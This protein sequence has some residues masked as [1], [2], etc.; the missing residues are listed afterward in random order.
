MGG[1]GEALQVVDER[2]AVAGGARAGEV[3]AGVPVE[4]REID[5]LAGDRTPMPRAP[6]TRA[7][8][9]RLVPVV[10]APLGEGGLGD[11][12]I[13][14]ASG[15]AV[16][17]ASL[18]RRA[19]RRPRAFAAAGVD[20]TVVEEREGA[21]RVLSLQPKRRWRGAIRMVASSRARAKPSVGLSPEEQLD[22]DALVDVERHDLG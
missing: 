7:S 18:S 4:G 15:T 3:G 10:L 12:E 16:A 17:R 14:S 11:G 9:S 20:R 1:R 13:T 8:S 5:E 19:S 6:T 22:R 2:G 21:G